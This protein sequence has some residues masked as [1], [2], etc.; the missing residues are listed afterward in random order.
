MNESEGGRRKTGKEKDECRQRREE[1]EIL[2]I[3]ILPLLELKAGILEEELRIHCA[4]CLLKGPL[5]S[6]ETFLC[7]STKHDPFPEIMV[8]L[9]LSLPAVVHLLN[10]L[11]VFTV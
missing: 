2:L 5:R 8:S 10:N 3:L 6:A 1:K 11:T 9:S 7:S 4:N